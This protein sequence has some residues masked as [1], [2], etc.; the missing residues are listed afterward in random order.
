LRNAI[1]RTG[2]A[3]AL[4]AA[5]LSGC[6]MVG[7]DFQSPEAVVNAGWSG[8]ESRITA[9]PGDYAHW[10]RMF[11][12]PALTRLEELGYQQ[13]L[14]LRVA[15]VRV[16]QARA[17][18]GVAIGQEYPQTQQAVGDLA[19]QRESARVPFAPTGKSSELEY[20]TAS[21]GVQAAWELDFWGKFRRFV[22]SADA[23]LAAN[24]AGY[25]D[26]LVSLTADLATAYVQLRTLEQQ[27]VVARAN[28]QVQQ[29]GLQIA[30]FRFRGGTTDERDVEQAKTILASTQA[31]IP[32]FEQQI[33][34]TKNAIAT[35]I[36]LPPSPLDDLLGTSKGIPVAPAQVG[37]G[38][39]ADLLRRRP[40]IRQ[41]EAVAAAQSALIGFQKADLLPSF[42]LVGT[43]GFAAS[44]WQQFDL[45]DIFL[46]KSRTFTFGPS[47]TWNFLNY[48]RI[49]NQV[50]AQDAAFQEALITYQN[51]VLVAQQEVE[52]AL[53]G[54]RKQQER[55]K[56]LSEAVRAAQRSLDLATLQYR[57]G[58]TDFTTVLVAEQQLLAQQDSL[59]VT[60]GAIP[61]NLVAVY[62]ALGGGWQIREG[63]AF[64]PPQTIEAMTR[65]TNWGSLLAYEVK[66]PPIPVPRPQRPRLPE[67]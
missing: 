43:F 56:V 62:R 27:L 22:E 9:Q 3:P 35:L 40:D 33:E 20:T 7:P 12:D 64:V 41:A 16:L 39:P 37:I 60:A 5:L 26:V 54:F 59:A 58:V 52:N 2:A 45:S 21:I 28:V 55:A 18:L 11:D 19:H 47:V 53:I 8:T 65:R 50:R 29:E 30:T 32:Q 10:W 66:V 4:A 42:T 36:G 14:P 6:A 31:T 49:T 23:Q 1:R 63:Q 24:V 25:D 34:Q 13:N 48:G 17:Q 61:S 51:T 67:W 57:S 38:I 44:D 15:G 46:A